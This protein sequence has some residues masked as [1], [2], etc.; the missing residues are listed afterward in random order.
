MTEPTSRPTRKVTAATFG[1]ACA[2]LVAWLA[3]VGLGVVMPPGVE[4][5]LATLVAAV[6]GWLSNEEG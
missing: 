5:A 2:V 3:Q 1:G 6:A 4:A